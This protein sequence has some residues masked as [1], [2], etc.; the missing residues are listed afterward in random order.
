MNLI[1]SSI[2]K[3]WPL[4]P[5]CQPVHVSKNCV[6]ILS[7]ET[8]SR[9]CLLKLCHRVWC[10]LIPKSGPDAACFHYVWITIVIQM[11]WKSFLENKMVEREGEERK[12]RQGKKEK[13]KSKVFEWTSVWG[14]KMWDFFHPHWTKISSVTQFVCWETLS[15]FLSFL[16]HTF[17]SFNSNEERKK[18]RIGSRQKG[19]YT[20]STIY[21]ITLWIQSLNFFLSISFFLFPNF[22]FFRFLSSC[23]P[24]FHPIHVPPVWLPS[25]VSSDWYFVFDQEMDQFIPWFGMIVN[26][27]WMESNCWKV[28]AEREEREI[29]RKREWN[30]KTGFVKDWKQHTTCWFFCLTISPLSFL[31]LPLSHWKNLFLTS[32]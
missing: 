28:N 12:E 13:G 6:Q 11:K 32:L 3:E 25:T 17:L 9:N 14:I 4:N 2:D 16:P 29:E 20:F 10:P 8:V 26:K 22:F 21:L 24:G 31:S 5:V 7:P 1:V 27:K 18:M 23:L 30:R 15:M 19:K